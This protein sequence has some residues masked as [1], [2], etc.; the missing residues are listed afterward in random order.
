MNLCINVEQNQFPITPTMG[1]ISK[2][3]L[4]TINEQLSV[5]TEPAAPQLIER[6]GKGPEQYFFNEAED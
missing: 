6:H 1:Y 3:H 2:K 5:H 4:P